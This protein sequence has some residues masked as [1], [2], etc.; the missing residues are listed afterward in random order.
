ME[1]LKRFF[2]INII[3]LCLLSSQAAERM[4]C[5]EDE[6]GETICGDSVPPSAIGGGYREYDKRGI[7]RRRIDPVPTEEE[8]ERRKAIDALRAERDKLRAEQEQYDNRL[9]TLFPHLDDLLRARDSKIA[10]LDDQIRVAQGEIHRLK[11]RLSEFQAVA[12]EAERLGKQPTAQQRTQIDDT[13]RSITDYYEFILGKE[14]EK[15]ATIEQYDIDLKRYRQ[16]REGSSFGANTGVVKPSEITSS[17]NPVVRC[18]RDSDCDRFWER[19]KEYARKHA[20]TPVDLVADRILATDPPRDTR[21]ISITVSRLPDKD[22]GGE[23]IFLDV[24]C[25]RLPDGM[26]FCLSPEVE[27]IRNEFRNALG[28]RSSER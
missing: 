17:F 4:K 9:L 10:Q 26:K 18:K 25:A 28:R 16:L 19:A 23:R 8:I 11:V 14:D 27:A 24:R 3:L 21:D 20:T 15:K 1:L 2:T 13:N 6:N 12:A 5:W 22:G 7:E